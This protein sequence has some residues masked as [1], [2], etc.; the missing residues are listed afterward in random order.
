MGSWCDG[1]LTVSGELS[2]LKEILNGFRNNGGKGKPAHV[3]VQL[4]YSRKYSDAEQGALDQWRT[5]IFEGTVLGDLSLPEQFDAMA[6]FVNI[7]DLKK[8]LL[9]SSDPDECREYISSFLDAGFERV[10][11]H[12]VNRQQEDFI[13]DFGDKVIPELINH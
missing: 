10:I 7:E 5:N 1:L 4:S 2:Q 9:I 3:K 8:K 6:E 12:N 13:K 11:I